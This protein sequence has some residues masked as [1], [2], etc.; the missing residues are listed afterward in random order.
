M[1]YLGHH[2]DGS[3]IQAHSVGGLYPFVI[4]AK[5]FDDGLGWG[6]LRPGAPEPSRY[7]RGPRA[8]DKAHMLAEAMLSFHAYRG[9]VA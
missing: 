6:V 8:Y 1:Q 7:F 3:S 9:E 5:Q 2:S 4:V